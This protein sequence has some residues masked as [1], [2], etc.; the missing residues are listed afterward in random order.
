MMFRLLLFRLSR[1]RAVATIIGGLIILSLI[2]TALGTMVFVS[3]QY[4]QYEQITVKM[5]QHQDQGESENLV[6]NSPG[7]TGPT[8]VS[9][10]GSTCNTYDM[11]LSNLGGVGVQIAR[12]YISSTGSGCTSPCI[13]NPSSSS[14]SYAFQQSTQFLNA[15]EVN[16]AV[17][18]YLPSTVVLPFTYPP[19][20]TI[21]IVTSRGN[22]F[23]FQWPF[24][25]QTGG[26]SQS[27]F[28]A[29]I[30]KVAYTQATSS[31]YDSAKEPAAGGSGGTGYCH[32]ESSQTYPAGASYAEKLTG[33]TA[34]A[35]DPAVGDS[36]NLWFVNPWVTGGIPTT[37]FETACNNSCPAN[38][39]GGT[40]TTTLY[41]AVNITNV[42][43]IPF[44]VAAGGLD[45]TWYG[46]NHIDGGLIGMY[47]NATG[48]PQF[49][50]VDSGQTVAVGKSFVAIFRI[51]E[52]QLGGWPPA[53]HASVMFWGS[54][55]FSDNT[56]GKTGGEDSTFVGAVSLLSG[57]WIRYSC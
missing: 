22:V 36:G 28:T 24:R 23:S 5:A 32:S 50:G 49:Y 16:H 1:R 35:G 42:G 43:N 47:Y 14:T 26:Q 57:L 2:L 44:T 41:L 29:G 7:L 52:V 6:A 55:S 4:D 48:T 38:Q 56:G 51:T 9:G 19:T 30:L 17:P 31:G 11:S 8:S 27:A 46:S 21:F 15:G 13:L 20:N 18:L 45:L 34:P 39:P 33:I 54:A 10:C 37:V 53:N 25:F 12:I 40:N 3:Q